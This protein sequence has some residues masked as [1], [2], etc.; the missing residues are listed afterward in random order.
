MFS[1]TYQF[2]TQ[3]KKKANK[4]ICVLFLIF[5]LINFLKMFSTVFLRWTK[6]NE[7]KK[8]H[9]YFFKYNEISYLEQNNT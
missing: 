8:H 2:L 6:E 5:N 3:L 1:E 7:T 4:K 9:K